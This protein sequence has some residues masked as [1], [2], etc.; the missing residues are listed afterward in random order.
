MVPGLTW[1]NP[2]KN[3]PLDKYLNYLRHCMVY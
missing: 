2:G 3:R 1:D